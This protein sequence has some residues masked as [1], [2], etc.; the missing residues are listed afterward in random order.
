M[1]NSITIK[2][3]GKRYFLKHFGREPY[4]ALRDVMVDTVRDILRHITHPMTDKKKNKK[5]EEFWALQD[6]NV[7]IK[8]GERI[9]IIG[10]NGAGKST[11]LKILSKITAPTTGFVK[12]RGRIASL[13]EVG[14]GFHQELTGR[15]NIFLNGAI[16]GM[17]RREIKRKF[18]E[19]VAFAEV[20]KFLD[21]PIKRYS[22]GMHVRLAFA[23]AA[24]LEP[25]ILLIDE[26]LAVGDELFQKKCIGKMED[27]GRGG[28]TILFVSHNLAAVNRLCSRAM[29]LHEGRLLTYGMT[30][31]VLGSYMEIASSSDNTK[32]DLTKQRLRTSHSNPDSYFKWTR[33]EILNSQQKPTVEIMYHEPFDIVFRGIAK[34][35]CE[36]VLIGLS[37]TSRTVGMIFT[38]HQTY[39]GLPDSLPEGDSEFRIRIDPNILAPDYY[40]IGIAAEGPRVGDWISVSIGF[41]ISSLG[42]T[43]DKIWYAPKKAGV[44]DYPVTW[45]MKHG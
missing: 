20:E 44:V 37:L 33:I 22:S 9:G 38:T 3:L 31:D 25:E 42:I 32:G 21:V 18:D 23:V 11:L 1:N 12:I 4:V 10:R 8:Q 7:Q 43:P 45:S 5:N 2:N 16:L 15:E 19:I 36:N 30:N 17:P 41:H 34:K 28:S 14:T 40:E 26:V 6:I 29:L 35:K 27:I 13:L 39:H 24:H